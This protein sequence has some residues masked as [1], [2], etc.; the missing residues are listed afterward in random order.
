M[1]IS[2][3]AM[4]AAYDVAKRVRDGTLSRAA[5]IEELQ[6][7]FALNR[8]SAGDTISNIGYMLEGKRYVRNK[9]CVCKRTPKTTQKQEFCTLFQIGY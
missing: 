6:Q 8:G 7:R 5:G 4:K 2:N 1:K 3:E 9:Q